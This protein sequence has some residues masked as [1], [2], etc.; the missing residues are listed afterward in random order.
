MANTQTNFVLSEKEVGYLGGWDHVLDKGNLVRIA[1]Q[2]DLY[3]YFCGMGYTFTFINGYSRY[4]SFGGK[5]EHDIQKTITLKKYA[6]EKGRFPTYAASEAIMK[7]SD[8]DDNEVDWKDRASDFM[9][10][11]ICEYIHV[12]VDEENCTITFKV[13]D[14]INHIIEFE[15]GI[16][17]FGPSFY[18]LKHL[19]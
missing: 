17:D 7:F 9:K 8:D 15:F 6:G 14:K 2:K 12:I 18:I 13:K 10:D 3:S 1:K 4:V 16:G 11:R 5:E 19:S